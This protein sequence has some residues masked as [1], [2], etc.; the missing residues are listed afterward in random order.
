[1]K[2]NQF[3]DLTVD[4]FQ[5]YMERGG[6]IK[7][8]L[9]KTEE[10]SKRNLNAVLSSNPSSIDWTTY[11]YVTPVKDQGQCG[12]CWAFSATG[13]L[14]CT[15]AKRW[16]KNYLVSLSEQ[17]LVDC[18][19][20]YGNYACGGGWPTK[21][22]QY[23]TANGGLC[24]GSQYPYQGYYSGACNA[25]CQYKY[26][27]ASKYA[28]VAYDNEGALE[29]AVA[30][31]CV[32]VLIEASASS[33]QFYS[34]GVYSDYCDSYTNHAVLAVGYGTSNGQNYW[35]I[36]NSWGTWWGSNGYIL[37]C[38]TCGKNGNDGQCGVNTGAS[39]PIT[40]Y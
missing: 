2:M 36:K 11:G 7:G 22:F 37:M 15:Y 27:Y 30:Q 34:S 39:Y 23:A 31:G 9:N 21:A 28:S 18:T 24:L 12:S 6:A 33:F 8:K 20:S 3:G 4:E 16:G 13:A 40:G 26:G 19:T 10:A 38:K 14:E 25:N 1:M 5:E 35:K 17:Q 29:T 32:S